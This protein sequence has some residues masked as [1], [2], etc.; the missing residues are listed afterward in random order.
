[1]NNFNTLF[2]MQVDT[3]VTDIHHQ[4]NYFNY[5][6]LLKVDSYYVKGSKAQKNIFESF[7]K[8]TFVKYL[9]F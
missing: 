7:C 5:K 9:L 1:M 8:E 3:H 4:F 2:Q 6:L